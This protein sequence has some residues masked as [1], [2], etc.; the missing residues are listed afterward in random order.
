MACRTPH[1]AFSFGLRMHGTLSLNPRLYSNVLRAAEVTEFPTGAAVGKPHRSP[2]SPNFLLARPWPHLP[3]LRLDGWCPVVGDRAT[4]QHRPNCRIC[5]P[6]H[7]HLA[8]RAAAI[9]IT[10]PFMIICTWIG[11]PNSSTSLAMTMMT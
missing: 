2:S 10:A 8:Y 4:V 11:N 3:K 7:D 5:S 1:R 6:L 9:T